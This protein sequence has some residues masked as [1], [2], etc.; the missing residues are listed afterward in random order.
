MIVGKN[1][2][3]KST[4]LKII[5][6]FVWPTKGHVETGKLQVGYVPEKMTLP[7]FTT[8]SS[9]LDTM[10]LLKGGSSEEAD[11]YLDYFRLTTAKDKKLKELSK[12]MLQKVVIIQA[13][14]GS[15][16]VLI[17]DEALNG[18][19]R[20]MQKKLLD[21]IDGEKKKGKIILITSHYQDYYHNVTTKTLEISDGCLWES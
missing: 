15:P 11:Y 18:L 7:L 20:E 10:R 1:G 19:D 12:G 8:V 17:F 4:L 16:D 21:L 6:G 3:G 14:L 5:L 2:A 13:F 9:F